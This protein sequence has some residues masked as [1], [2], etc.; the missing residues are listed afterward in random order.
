MLKLSGLWRRLLVYTETMQKAVNTYRLRKHNSLLST[1]TSGRNTDGSCTG[2]DWEQERRMRTCQS[3]HD[4]SIQERRRSIL[5][6]PDAVVE[7]HRTQCSVQRAF[8]RT[9]PSSWW[10]RR[11]GYI[12]AEMSPYGSILEQHLKQVYSL[13]SPFYKNN[14]FHITI[15]NMF[16]LICRTYGI[17]A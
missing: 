12:E 9:L 6:C 17:S 15:C 14:A 13:L 3:K 7:R 16:V 2:P 5:C 10:W 1:L 8:C 4:R 11:H